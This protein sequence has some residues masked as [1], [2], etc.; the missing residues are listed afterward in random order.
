MG[1]R[2]LRVVGT[3]AGGQE[4]GRVSLVLLSAVPS[5]AGPV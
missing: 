4:R 5:C 2:V 3:V 1:I